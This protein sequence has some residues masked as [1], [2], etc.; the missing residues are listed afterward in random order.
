MV[1]IPPASAG[2]VGLIQEDPTRLGAAIE[3]VL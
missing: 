3:L 1:K 2:D